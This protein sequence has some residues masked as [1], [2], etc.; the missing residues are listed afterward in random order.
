MARINVY[1]ELM[2]ERMHGS[3][4]AIAGRSGFQQKFE[5]IYKQ[6]LTI[7]GARVCACLHACIRAHVCVHVCRR[8][9]VCVCV[10]VC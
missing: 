10:C 6:Y 3:D 8:A 1:A 9:C 2:E 7:L 4:E 5:Q